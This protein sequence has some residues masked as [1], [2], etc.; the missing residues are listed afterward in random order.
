[1]IIK[2]PFNNEQIKNLKKYQKRGDR[3]PFTCRGDDI[4]C[5]RSERE[6][7]GILIPKEE[8]M[9]CP[10]GKYTQKWVHDFMCEKQPNK[11]YVKVTIPLY[12]TN[13]VLTLKWKHTFYNFNL[14]YLGI[15]FYSTHKQDKKIWTRKE[16]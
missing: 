6:D 15:G 1:M 9:V 2:A 10:C 16:N 8:G 4:N 14:P 5:N 3:H 7:G 11:D 13:L 12:F